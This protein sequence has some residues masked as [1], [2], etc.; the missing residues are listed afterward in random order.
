MMN[1]LE[2]TVS[3]FPAIGYL[4]RKNDARKDF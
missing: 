2:N 1:L 3:L 4:I